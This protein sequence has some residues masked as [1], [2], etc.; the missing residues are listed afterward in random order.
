MIDAD[1]SVLGCGWMGRPLA[2]ALVDCDVSVRG[3]TT[4]PEKVETLRQEGI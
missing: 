1:V 4:T 2:N 3:S